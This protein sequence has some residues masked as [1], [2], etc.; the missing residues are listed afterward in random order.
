MKNVKY[1]QLRINCDLRIISMLFK[2]CHNLKHTIFWCYFS[3][4]VS[5]FLNSLVDIVNICHFKL[6]KVYWLQFKS[7]A[8][9]V[10]IR[11]NKSSFW[12]ILC[13]YEGNILYMNMISSFGLSFAVTCVVKQQSATS[14]LILILSYNFLT[15]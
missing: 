6:A 15:M 8:I 3:A 9:K 12:F 11:T 5:C 2:F 7:R 10:Y 4:M 14:A 13:F 1:G